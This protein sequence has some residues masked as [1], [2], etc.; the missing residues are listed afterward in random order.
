MEIKCI[1]VG[2]IDAKSG[3]IKFVS[4]AELRVILK[5]R[6]KNQD[7][8]ETLFL[9]VHD[10]VDFEGGLVFYFEDGGGGSGDGGE[11]ALEAREYPTL[12]KAKYARVF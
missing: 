2:E 1:T 10:H 12:S 6:E 9:E 5:S 11:G 3:I 7:F 4:A 8:V